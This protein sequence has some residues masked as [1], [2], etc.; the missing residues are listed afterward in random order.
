MLVKQGW[1]A[2]ENAFWAVVGY[3]KRAPGDVW[4]WIGNVWAWIKETAKAGFHKV[5]G[6]G[7]LGSL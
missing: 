5:G 2:A 1:E 4:V 7:E 6:G 3:V